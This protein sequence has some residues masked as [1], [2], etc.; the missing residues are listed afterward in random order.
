M[1]V[2]NSLKLKK[3]KNVL[4]GLLL[5]LSLC[6]P[7]VAEDVRI[8]ADDFKTRNAVSQLLAPSLR[9]QLRDLAANTP[10]PMVGGVV[11]TDRVLSDK[12]SERE[13][14]EDRQ[15]LVRY[16]FLVARM[17][18]SQDFSEEFARR[19][20]LTRKGHTLMRAYIDNL[21]VLIGR[22]VIAVNQPVDPPLIQGFPLSKVGWQ[23]DDAGV[24]TLQVL[25]EFPVPSSQFGRES[26]RALRVVAETDLHLLQQQ[27]DEIDRA[28]DLFLKEVSYLGQELF[29]LRPEVQQ[30]VRIPRAG[31]PFSF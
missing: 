24:E 20:D 25:H 2:L 23:K 21:N 14:D 8:S 3:Q 29:D 22:A 15:A 13:W 7:V 4:S 17:E 1:P 6:G 5:A 27:L 16:Y 9:L 19:R 12:F 11:E 30:L 10:L 28:E 26:L 31:L 18:K